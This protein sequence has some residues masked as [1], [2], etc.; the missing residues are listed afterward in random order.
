[1]SSAII[2]YLTISNLK[3]LNSYRKLPLDTPWGYLLRFNTHISLKDKQWLST[4]KTQRLGILKEL[5][6]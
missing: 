5:F 2:S 3:N 4:N 1:M 6:I